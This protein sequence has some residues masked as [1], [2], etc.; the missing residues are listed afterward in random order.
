MEHNPTY[1]PI[2]IIKIIGTVDFLM[3]EWIDACLCTYIALIALFI[4]YYQDNFNNSV[5]KN[6]RGTYAYADLPRNKNNI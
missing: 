4:I 1:V 5:I 2:F 3:R 6:F